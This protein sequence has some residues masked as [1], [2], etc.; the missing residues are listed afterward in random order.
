MLHT[1]LKPT[2]SMP[3][4]MCAGGIC[5]SADTKVVIFSLDFVACCIARR[6]VIDMQEPGCGDIAIRAD[7]RI[8]AVAAWSG[9]IRLYHR[10][11][12]R[13]LAVLQVYH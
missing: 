5:G 7:H 2:F 10:R 11:K 12:H 3:C 8:F 4:C 6:H 13:L 9:K 1:V